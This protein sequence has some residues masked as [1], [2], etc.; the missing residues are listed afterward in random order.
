MKILSAGDVVRDNG[1]AVASTLSGDQTAHEYTLFIADKNT[2]GDNKVTYILKKFTVVN[3]G[4]G[5]L[6]VT[7]G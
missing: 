1:N 5:V 3:D 7:D 6:T 4:K 2:G